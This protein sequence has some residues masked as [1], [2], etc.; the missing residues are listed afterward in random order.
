MAE[1]GRRRKAV[2]ASTR[3]PARPAQAERP[4]A[5]RRR[6]LD[7]PGAHAR[8]RPARAS[9]CASSA[10]SSPSSWAAATSSAAWPRRPSGFDRATG[11]LHRHDRHRAERPRPAGRPRRRGRRHAGHERDRDQ[12]GLRA[13]HQAARP[14][15]HREGARRHLRRRHRQPVLLDRLGGGPA[16][17]RARRR[18]HPHGQARVRRRLRRRPRA[19]CPRRAFIPEITHL[20]RSSAASRSWTPRRCR[21]AWTTG[22]RSTCSR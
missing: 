4:G 3:L 6:S 2:R 7:R 16:R 20:R 10:S 11:R 12:G 18:G 19:R 13:V 8:D 14:A 17:A 21:C 1:G 5:G 9:A 22:C 15:P